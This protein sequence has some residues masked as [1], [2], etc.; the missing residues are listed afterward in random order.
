MP[1]ASPCPDPVRWGDLLDS[2][3]TEPVASTLTS[4]LEDCP[5]CQR[6]LDRLTA[7]EPDWVE[8][9]RT[10]DRRPR[11]E[12]RRAMEQLKAE[13]ETGLGT[14]GS[15]TFVNEP[16]PFLRP[17]VNPEHLGR[18]GPY[19]V[20]GVIGRGGMGVVL[21]AFDPALRRMTAIKVMAPQWASHKEARQRFEREARA[22]AL[23]RHENVVAIHAVEQADGLPYLVMEYVPGVSLQQHLD[24][25]GPLALEDVLRIGA[26]VAAGLAAAHARD[27]V[28]RDVKPANILLDPNGTVRLTDFGMARAVDDSS[29]TQPG[30][31]AGTPQYM[32][33]EQARGEPVDH[34]ADL[35]SLG[36]VLYAMCT[37]HPPFRAPTTVAV[38][39]RVCDEMPT[40]VRDYNP[41][42]PGWLAEIIDRLHAKRPRDRFRGAI[43]VGRLLTRHLR[44]LRDP[45]KFD[46]PGPVGRP[47]PASLTPWLAVLV[48]PAGVVAALLIWG[49]VYVLFP[50]AGTDPSTGAPGQGA[51]AKAPP[52]QGPR[53]ADDVFFQKVLAD[54]DDPD[55]FTRKAALERLATMKPNDRRADVAR[56]L[57][58]L[59]DV[60][61]PFHRRAAVAALGMWGSEAEV[62]DLMAAMAHKDLFTRRE[63]LKVI[64]G[65]RDARTLPPVIQLF[66]EHST[67][68]D[69]G[70]A[71]RQLGVMAEP[72]VLA[73]LKEDDVFLKRDAI[74]VLKD[75]GTD[76]SVPALRE[77]AANGRIH[78][79]GPA[80]Q[81]LAAI[82]ERRQP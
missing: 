51:Q 57:V 33:P 23:V 47:K 62:P 35:F 44:H 37:G 21:K 6:T 19:E 22:A 5:G 55:H 17:S 54:L 67:R 77:A 75:I 20:L 26:Q 27:L 68:G 40:D 28:H 63:A 24:R 56:K 31:I 59:L 10:L 16:L 78:V 39:R 34:R 49:A 8:A 43:E 29:L 74:L 58:A 32:A 36:S 61:D 1:T 60:D 66:R 76:A 41:D 7:G 73:L 53:A 48:V 72:D 13:G 50:K 18:L 45:D 2:R 42:V 52:G 11:P 79:T 12:L 65:F 69:A 30:V 38:L 71:L 9:A 4:H 82:A 64:G 81:A 70:Q 46:R 14:A 3:L 25:N 80:Q 15:S